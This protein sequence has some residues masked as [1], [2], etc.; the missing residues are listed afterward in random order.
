MVFLLLLI[1]LP[2]GAPLGAQ[3]EATAGEESKGEKKSFSS[4]I[5]GF[6]EGSVFFFPED[7]GMYS[8]PMKVLPSLGGGVSYS[9]TDKIRAEFSLDLYTSHYGYS[10]VLNRAVPDAIEN[11]TARV[12]SFLLGFQATAYFNVTPSITV[13]AF[14]G[15]VAD[16]RIIFLAED[17]DDGLDDLAAIRDD[18][19]D[20][21][22]YFWSRGRWFL[23][24]IGAG[25][26]FALNSRFKL[27]IDMRIWIPIY[28]LWSGE[29]LPKIEGWRFGPGIRL[30]IR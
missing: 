8:D 2:L 9:F 13:R 19:D 15:P 22:G 24:V 12:I 6:V 29:D 14:G 3:E 1:I 27:G 4:R 18:V 26:D 11:R 28:R 25:V 17:L 5:S 30:T 23:P 16:L 20:V 7:N 10:S 21:R